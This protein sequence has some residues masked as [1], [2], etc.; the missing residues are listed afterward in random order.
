VHKGVA[1]WLAADGL[2]V[3]RDQGITWKLQ[4]KPVD[5]T[6]G[7]MIDPKNGQRF[8]VAGVKG[9]F[10]TV[11][12]GQTWTAVAASLPPEFTM[13]KAGWY[14]TVAWDPVRDVFYASQM[15]K[16]TYRLSAAR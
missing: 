7:P 14:A 1:Y 9:I 12:G 13:P 15:G 5:G 6:I 4:G 3:S 10:Q 11:D 16:P 8:V 2:L